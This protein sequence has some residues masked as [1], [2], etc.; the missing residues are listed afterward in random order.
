MGTCRQEGNYFDL[1]VS[2]F[3]NRFLRDIGSDRWRVARKERDDK[4]HQMRKR[5]A[6]VALEKLKAKQNLARNLIAH[7][8]AMS[9][10]QPPTI[11]PP[12]HVVQQTKQREKLEL[13]HRKEREAKEQR[14][15]ED[16]PFFALGSA[17][18]DESSRYRFWGR[19]RSASI[20]DPTKMYSRVRGLQRHLGVK[21]RCR[22][23]DS[24]PPGPIN[25]S[26]FLMTSTG[27][28]RK[29]A[30]LEIE[31][32]LSLFRQRSDDLDDLSLE[33]SLIDQRMSA[34][35]SRTDKRL[36]SNSLNKKLR[37]L[38]GKCMLS[39][40]LPREIIQAALDSTDY[41]HRRRRTIGGTH[42]EL[43]MY[44]CM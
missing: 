5:I 6:E 1:D 2:L 28:D 10:P 11:P 40:R 13:K 30:I 24:L 44:V 7:A 9:K 39:P 26:F 27:Q 43:C 20:G 34:L 8:E 33:I 12:R 19:Q 32:S 3:T 25:T 38:N 31:H 37:N 21:T 18:L 35:T 17:D 23:T 22:R 29:D 14:E 41:S 4:F 15:R 16:G 42:I 36:L